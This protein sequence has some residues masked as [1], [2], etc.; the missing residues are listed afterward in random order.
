[1]AY[2]KTAWVDG[3][4]PYINAANLNHIE[5]GVAAAAL[6]QEGV[7]TVAASGATNTLPDV[8]VATIHN[9]T[10][11][12]NCTLTFPTA[13]AGKSFM[14]S[15]K[16]DATGGRT[17]TWP[18]TV[19]KWPGGTAPTLTTTANAIDVVSFLCVDGTNWYGFIAGKDIK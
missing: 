2:T 18:S 10:L 15:L 13:G 12:A 6:L 9:I 14:V 5:N 19:V 1:M 11:T 17:V 16:Q 8:T 3:S 4:V 7:N